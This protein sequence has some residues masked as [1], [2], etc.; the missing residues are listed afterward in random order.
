MGPL[1]FREYLNEIQHDSGGGGKPSL[2]GTSEETAGIPG[3]RLPD[4]AFVGAR[5]R[6]LSAV[7]DCRAFMAY[8]RLLPSERSSGKK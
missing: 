8:L 4:G 5:D 3:Y 6:G 1:T 2:R 7:P